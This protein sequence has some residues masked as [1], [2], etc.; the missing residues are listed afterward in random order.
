MNVG[1]GQGQGQEQWQGQG[2]GQG[3]GLPHTLWHMPYASKDR[4]SYGQENRRAEEYKSKSQNTCKKE[5]AM[6]AK[7]KLMCPVPPNILP[8]Y[9]SKI[10]RFK[11]QKITRTEGYNNIKLKS[12]TPGSHKKSVNK[13]YPTNLLMTQ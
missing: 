1:E 9:S 6:K 7:L 10:T 5:E 4:R 2:Q 3:Q 11:E 8:L 12:N 13:F